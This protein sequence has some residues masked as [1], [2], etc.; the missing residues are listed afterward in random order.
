MNSAHL[1][2]QCSLSIYNS[3]W[4]KVCAQ[5]MYWVNGYWL[6]R[7]HFTNS[8]MIWALCLALFPST[9]FSDIAFC[10][11]LSF[12]LLKVLN[13]DVS[14]FIN[15]YSRHP[16]H[17]LI[18]F[19]FLTLHILPGK[20]VNGHGLSVMILV[21]LT[22]QVQTFLLSFKLVHLPAYLT[23]QPDILQSSKLNMLKIKIL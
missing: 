12:W 23:S 7:L 19:S 20:L 15:V 8:G 4:H 14:S 9:G 2:H 6:S 3:V 16:G 21:Q 10:I 13:T 5:Y 22:P 17:C 1:V 11:F 18:H